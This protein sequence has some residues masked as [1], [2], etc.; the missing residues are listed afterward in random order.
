MSNSGAF[1]TFTIVQ[2]SPLSSSK[3]FSSSQKEIQYQLSSYSS[4]PTSPWGALIWVPSLWIYLFWI[5]HSNWII[6]CV[7]FCV[8]LLSLSITFSRFI[9]VTAFLFTAEQ[10]SLVWTCHI[11]LI[12][13]PADGHLGCFHLLWIMLLRSFVQVL[14]WIPVFNYFVPIP[15]SRNSGRESIFKP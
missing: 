9:H 2:A 6:Q 1:S 14:V 10:Y 13:S 3:T 4:L 12:H 11:L 7:T 8:W 5:F 15:R